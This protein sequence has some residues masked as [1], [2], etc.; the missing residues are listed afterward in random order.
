MRLKSSPGSSARRTTLGSES[1][2]PIA[3][4][5]D[6]R[7]RAD[8]IGQDLAEDTV[9]CI[10]RNNKDCSNFTAI[11]QKKNPARRCWK[12][13]GHWKDNP[14]ITASRMKPG[15]SMVCT[16][17][18]LLSRAASLLAFIVLSFSSIV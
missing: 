4:R 2:I 1:L 5:H 18:A 17:A 8:G 12:K 15:K 9:L 16:P 3:W 14:A 7:T 10:R 11:P 13:E 6:L